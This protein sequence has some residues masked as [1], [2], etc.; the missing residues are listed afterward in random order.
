MPTFSLGSGI[1][2]SRDLPYGPRQAFEL[3][4][5][6]IDDYRNQGLHVD[7]T[8][9]EAP[10]ALSARITN[11]EGTD[12]HADISLARQGSGTRIALELKG[13]V[14]VGGWAGRLATNT[15]VRKE[16]EKRLSA[17][18]DEV[19]DPRRTPVEASEDDDGEDE[20]GDDDEDGLAPAAE[21][22]EA[23]DIAP[24]QPT[25]ASQAET[26][27]L[28]LRDMRDKGLI[29]EDDFQSKRRQILA[30]L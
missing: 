19:F 20:G 3:S 7:F 28:M 13:D 15:I 16:A 17:L 29:T 9:D 4:R 26:R 5:R 18:V 23:P 2:I 25:P 10:A 14:F 8:R 27:L 1:S 24:A 6:L 22:A 11:R 30:K 21:L 12:L